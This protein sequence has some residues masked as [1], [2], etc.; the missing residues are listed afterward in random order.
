METIINEKF[1]IEDSIGILVENFG[2]K[3]KAAKKLLNE[4]AIAKMVNEMYTAQE[5]YLAE[6]HEK[7]RKSGSDTEEHN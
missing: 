6:L 2:M 4:N 5:S 1:L 7:I 3:E